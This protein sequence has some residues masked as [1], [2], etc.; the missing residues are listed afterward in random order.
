MFG[1]GLEIIPSLV[2][3]VKWGSIPL[4]LNMAKQMTNM[5]S[6]FSQD[7][8]SMSS[9]WGSLK[10]MR[11]SQL[12]VI[13]CAF[14]LKGKASLWLLVYPVL[15]FPLILTIFTAVLTIAYIACIYLQ[16]KDDAKFNFAG[17]D[18]GVSILK[19]LMAIIEILLFGLL[20][21][22]LIFGVSQ[23]LLFFT[24]LSLPMVLDI[25][26]VAVL[27]LAMVF[28]YFYEQDN[29]IYNILPKSI[30]DWFSKLSLNISTQFV[31]SEALIPNESTLATSTPEGNANMLDKKIKP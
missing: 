24:S 26:Y 17:D 19:S 15:I 21:A 18:F 13:F 31:A 2:S 8:M 3:A 1:I 20:I 7:K 29:I 30:T 10:S 11:P 22:G 12:S 5:S 25:S 23:A 14:I 28:N 9:M 6:M 27:A 16:S 4:G